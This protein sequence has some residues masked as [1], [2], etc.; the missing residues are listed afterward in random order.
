D[1]VPKLPTIEFAINL[2]HPNSMGYAPFFLNPIQMPRPMMW[3]DAKPDKYPGGRVYAQRV[4]AVVM[5]VHNSIIAM[6]V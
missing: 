6:R 4:K 5:A 2:A 1:W 3:D